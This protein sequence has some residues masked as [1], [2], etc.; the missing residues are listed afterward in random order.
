[1]TFLGFRI[2]TARRYRHDM[3]T[4]REVGELAG[5]LAARL[6]VQVLDQVAGGEPRRW[7]VNRPRRPRHLYLVDPVS[8]SEP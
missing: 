6:D 4:A 3:A 1:V 7:P 2:M 8:R 5:R